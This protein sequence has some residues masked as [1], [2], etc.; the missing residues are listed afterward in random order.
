MKYSRFGNLLIALIIVGIG[1]P[2]VH[3][4]GY[5]RVRVKVSDKSDMERILGITGES[6]SVSEY[7]FDD[8]YIELI[9]NKSQQEEVRS[10]GY[11]I[12]III[13]N[14]EEYYSIQFSGLTMGGFRTYSEIRARLDS[15][16]EQYSYILRVDSIG[17]SHE[18]RAILAV[19]VS[20]NVNVEEE[21]PEVLFTGITHAREP[22][23]GQ[24]C[25]EFMEWLCENYGENPDATYIVNERQIWFIPVVNPDGYVY[26]QTTNPNG[27]GMWRKNRR[28]NGGSYGVDN[29]R[30]Y[31]YMWGYDNNGS[32]SDPSSQTYRGP[33][34]GSEICQPPSAS[35]ARPLS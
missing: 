15:L 22:I 5:S 29:N 4:D 16:E 31:T 12:E 9:L 8:W 26:N 17:Y 27:G 7:N 23:G 21:E 18:N 13:P 35:P 2:S 25:I 33:S 24:I 20:D 34:A 32:S 28:N 30:N 3:A 1:Y 6:E 11:D 19:K 10:L 14:M